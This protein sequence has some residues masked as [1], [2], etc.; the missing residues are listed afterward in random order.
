LYYHSINEVKLNTT[1]HVYK[2]KNMVSS[3][4]QLAST[5]D[6]GYEHRRNSKHDIG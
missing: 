2:H 1:Q 5:A 3:G 6:T 4:C